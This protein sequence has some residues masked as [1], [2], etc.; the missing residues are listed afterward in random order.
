MSRK[1]TKK[2]RF[3]SMSQREQ[4]WERKR[5]LKAGRN[6]GNKWGERVLKK[7]ETQKDGEPIGDNESKERKESQK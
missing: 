6:D 2:A 1:S 7:L 3:D 5:K 4:N